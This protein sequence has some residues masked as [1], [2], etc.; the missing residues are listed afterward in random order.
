MTAAYRV[1]TFSHYKGLPLRFEW[2]P[3]KAADNQRKHGISFEMAKLVFSDPLA[4]T[5]QDRIEGGEYR[6]QTIGTIDEFLVV[7]VAHTVRA[8]D[9][10]EVIRIVSARRATPRERR[11]YEQEI[12]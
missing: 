2:D 7:I 3:A 12:R 1:V 6:W 4:R 10:G 8:D 9:D 5:E 11:R